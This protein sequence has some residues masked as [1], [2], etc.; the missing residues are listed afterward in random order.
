L[1]IQ[2]H[3]QLA[4]VPV[5]D[6]RSPADLAFI[7]RQDDFVWLNFLNHW[8]TIKQNHGFFENLKDRWMPTE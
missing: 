2:S 4:I 6:P 8:I 5:S 1:L 7:V 3:P